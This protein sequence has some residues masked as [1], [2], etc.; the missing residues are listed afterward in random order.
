MQYQPVCGC[1]GKTY[2]NPCMAAA[3]YQNIQYMVCKSILVLSGTNL[4]KLMT[5][6]YKRV[7]ATEPKLDYCFM[8]D[9]LEYTN[10]IIIDFVQ[11]LKIKSSNPPIALQ[12]DSITLILSYKQWDY[13]L[14]VYFLRD[15]SRLSFLVQN[16]EFFDR[17]E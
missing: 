17:I 11:T 6:S 7:S 2:G 4:T 8:S 15:W 13:A 10:H 12:T 14:D 1:D 5:S 3:S 16:A 9:P